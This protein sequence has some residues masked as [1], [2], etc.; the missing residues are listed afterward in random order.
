MNNS[1]YLDKPLLPLAVASPPLLEHIEAEL[2]DE[3]RGTTE[4]RCLRQRSELMRRPL[5]VGR[6]NAAQRGLRPLLTT[7]SAHRLTVPPR[8]AAEMRVIIP[9]IV[10]LVALAATSL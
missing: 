1:R 9:T 8:K 7:V 2:A 6:V 4:K 5:A 3:T 10:G